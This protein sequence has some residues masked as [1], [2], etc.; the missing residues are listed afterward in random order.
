MGR[1]RR[2]S[3]ARWAIV[4]RAITNAV[5]E[6]HRIRP[7][8]EEARAAYLVATD[9]GTVFHCSARAVGEDARWRWWF[10]DL[11]APETRWF[12]G[13]DWSRLSLTELRAAV[14]AWWVE[15]K[16]FNGGESIPEL[17]AWM[18][19]EMARDN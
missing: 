11:A 17:R 10:V 15:R 4:R 6:P 7:T 16:A 2:A 5:L 9:D 3:V 8:P 13:P 1:R 12:L 19:R 18:M 14:N